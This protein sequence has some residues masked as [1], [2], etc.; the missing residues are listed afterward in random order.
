MTDDYIAQLAGHLPNEVL[1]RY[2]DVID[3]LG[4]RQ[5]D[6]R[7]LEAELIEIA[8][9]YG[10]PD[11]DDQS[12]RTNASIQQSLGAVRLEINSLWISTPPDWICPCCKRTKPCCARLGTKDQMLGKLVAHH[13]HIEELITV[14]LAELSST[15]T[16]AA[17]SSDVLRRFL[18]RGSDLFARFE[19]IIICEDCNNAEANAKK[20]AGAREHFTFTPREITAFICPAP[21]TPHRIDEMALA[22]VYAEAVPLFDV[23]FASLKK[24][25]ERA[26][27]GAAWYEPVDFGDR[28]C[29]VDRHAQRALNRFGLSHADHGTVRE[30]FLEKSKVDRKHASAWRTKSHPPP[31][32]PTESQLEFVLRG[33]STYLALPE[34]WMCPGCS[35][36]KKQIAR[37]SQNS[38]Q[39]M[40]VT[41]TRN[42]PD[43]AAR[44]GTR[45]IE[46]CDACNHTF[47]QCHKELRS[48][49][50]YLGMPDAPVTLDQIQ[51]IIMPRPHALHDIDA[52]AAETLI[53]RR[54]ADLQFE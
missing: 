47:Q 20:M 8:R 36:P 22:T 53:R 33:H 43:P 1:D 38:K 25:A 16:I 50:G 37:W 49:L 4:A 18:R 28:D 42:I 41:G 27:A 21:N 7:T 14:M 54:L 17:E 51:A 45:K 52:R 40:F 9:C 44:N 12:S 31:R 26:L 23:R 2:L 35:R 30:I 6:I 46:L 5:S 15:I 3:A 39:F 24:L 29:G 13:D 34:D 48:E 19:R 10:V 11:I 32:I